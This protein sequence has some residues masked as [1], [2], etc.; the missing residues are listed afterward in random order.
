MSEYWKSIP[1]Y[2]CKHCKTYVR[3]TPLEKTNHE[4]TPRHQG[5][6]KRFLR[7]LYK[8]N[9]KSERAKQRAKDEVARL[10]G[11]ASAPASGDG[12]GQ[13][14]PTVTFKKTASRAAT[15]DERKRQMNQLAEMG[16]AVPEDF[17]RE[18]AM[19]GDWEIIN[20]RIIMSE[21]VRALK[22][23]DVDMKPGLNV[24]VRKRKAEED[25]EEDVPKLEE[26]RRRP[27]YGRDVKTLPEDDDD[28]DAL[29]GSTT[30]FTKKPK[31]EPKNEAK[32]TDVAKADETTL[33][34]QEASS[35]AM[36]ATPDDDGVLPEIK[37]EDV[38]ASN[39]ADDVVYESKAK[40]GSEDEDLGSI[41]K[42]RKPKAIRKK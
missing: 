24:G 30:T 3:D 41:F 22:E 16:I 12:S 36:N 32:A 20:Q 5:N 15:V 1:S 31:L 9:D 10:N 19:A 11:T 39:G 25:A 26:G 40:E 21:G 2:W 18:N 8:E 13:F 34:R 14:K 23:E 38:T 37:A 27:R 28:L 33:H 4:A 6:L 17:R 7:D 29:L 35:L 42:K